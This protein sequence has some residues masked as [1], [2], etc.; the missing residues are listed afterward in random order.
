MQR[1]ITAEDEESAVEK[2]I[3]MIK[4]SSPNEWDRMGEDNIFVKLKPN[5]RS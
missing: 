3:Y 2:F 5:N 1:Y 4:K